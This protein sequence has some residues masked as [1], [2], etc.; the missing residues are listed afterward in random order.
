V[1]A[2]RDGCEHGFGGEHIECARIVRCRHVW[3]FPVVLEAQKGVRN[4]FEVVILTD[5]VRK[6]IN[7]INDITTITTSTTSFDLIAGPTRV[8]SSQPA[9]TLLGHALLPLSTFEVVIVV[10][11]V[12]LP[13][14]T[15]LLA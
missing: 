10:I 11:V 5:V 6:N 13:D 14:F 7:K 1:T 2:A 3:L 15:G 4:R 12:M 9:R 8:A